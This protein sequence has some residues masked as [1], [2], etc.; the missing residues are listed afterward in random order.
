MFWLSFGLLSF[1][2]S[3]NIVMSD[4]R[5][6][7]P[8]IIPKTIVPDS[9]RQKPVSPK[10]PKLTITPIAVTSDEDVGEKIVVNT[11]TNVI[12]DDTSGTDNVPIGHVAHF[13]T[14]SLSPTDTESSD[15][16]E[17]RRS[18]PPPRSRSP[19]FK[20][21]RKKHKSKTRSITIEP[22]DMSEMI[23]KT[24][25][26]GIKGQ[27]MNISTGL[28]D[29]VKDSIED[30]YIDR[31]KTAK[32]TAVGTIGSFVI[33]VVMICMIVLIKKI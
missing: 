8:R 31:K 1:I 25:A 11:K 10:V 17:P 30:L 27:L 28:I 29:G 4:T 21:T 6:K 13:Q 12:D 22:D 20:K 16:Y 14:I 2:L 19:V 15:D 7:P 32:K 18:Q 5:E 26:D 9:P 24:D 3:I 33:I 23:N